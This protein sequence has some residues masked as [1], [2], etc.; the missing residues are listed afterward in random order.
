VQYVL[1]GLVLAIITASV[2]AWMRVTGGD[3]GVA[4]A[5][6]IDVSDL[7]VLPAGPDIRVRHAVLTVASRHIPLVSVRKGPR[8]GQAWLCFADGTELLAEE[9]VLGALGFLALDL[10]MRRPTPTIAITT[11]TDDC[12]VSV[13]RRNTRLRLVDVHHP[14]TLL[15]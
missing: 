6:L 4:D 3:D 5:D 11:L 8:V 2:A 15:T 12:W 14:Q 1:L 9:P 7:D 10:E 13:G